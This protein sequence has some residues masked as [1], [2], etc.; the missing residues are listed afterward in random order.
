MHVCIDEKQVYCAVYCDSLAPD[1][2]SS[3]ALSLSLIINKHN[4]A[5]YYIEF[6]NLGAMC[7]RAPRE[8]LA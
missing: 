5:S 4:A 7:A 6:T 3:Y 8:R 1:I 2:Q